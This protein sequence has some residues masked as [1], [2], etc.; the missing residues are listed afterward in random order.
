MLDCQQ[1]LKSDPYPILMGIDPKTNAVLF[2]NSDDPLAE[3]NEWEPVGFTP[4]PPF[5]I[6]E[7]YTAIGLNG[8]I[9][10]Y[11]MFNGAPRN[12]GLVIA[13]ERVPLQE[14]TSFWQ[15]VS[16]TVYL[17]SRYGNNKKE[18]LP[19]NVVSK[20]TYLS[21]LAEIRNDV[22]QLLEDVTKVIERGK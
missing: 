14:G 19:L 21:N 10:G 8:G 5:D 18:E 20:R 11:V 4:I 15:S 9:V 22:S 17:H 2:I 1:L 13:G 6:P 7:L 3:S 12:N 16:K